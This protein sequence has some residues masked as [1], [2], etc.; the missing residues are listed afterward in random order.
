MFC[1]LLSWSSENEISQKILSVKVGPEYRLSLPAV[2]F[3][4]YLGANVA[5]NS[6]SGEFQNNGVSKLS[7]GTYTVNPQQE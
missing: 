6:F 4:P 5:F 2:P 3:T 1:S 7:S